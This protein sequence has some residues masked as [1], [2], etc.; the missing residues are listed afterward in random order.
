[1][2][3]TIKELKK[4]MIA[5]ERRISDLEMLLVGAANENAELKK[6]LTS[7]LH[8]SRR[9]KLKDALDILNSQIDRLRELESPAEV[10]QL[11]TALRELVTDHLN[12]LDSMGSQEFFTTWVGSRYHQQRLLTFNGS[13]GFVPDWNFDDGL[14]VVM[15]WEKTK[16]DK[17]DNP[18]DN[19]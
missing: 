17:Q 11:K 1:M 9:V 19:T 10:I 3:D 6:A 12:Q 14:E 13:I 15:G 4:E 16:D 5:L 18:E 8:R 2:E 7:S